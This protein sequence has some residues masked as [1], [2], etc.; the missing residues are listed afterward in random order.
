M[1]CG[2][3]RISDLLCCWNGKPADEGLSAGFL[4]PLI[5][6][7]AHF[8]CGSEPAREGG[9]TGDLFLTECMRSNC[10]SEP[11]RDKAHPGARESEIV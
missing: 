4:L 11:A 10:G 9:L 8:H 7:R 5:F 1:R 6:V 3:W 2:G